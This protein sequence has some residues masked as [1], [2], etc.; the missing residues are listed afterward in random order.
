MLRFDKMPSK[1]SC[2]QVSSEIRWIGSFQWERSLAGRLISP[3]SPPP[4]RSDAGEFRLKGDEDACKRLPTKSRATYC[5][6]CMMIIKI[7][8]APSLFAATTIE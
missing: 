2:K 7:S 6:N 1:A 8:T 3:F 5:G 4:V